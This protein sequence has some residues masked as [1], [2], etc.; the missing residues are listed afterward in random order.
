MKELVFI[1]SENLNCEP[2]TTD[3]VVAEL[4]GIK[5]DSVKSLI[6]R[7]KERLELFGKVKYRMQRSSKS[8]N[9][10]GGQC[11]KTYLLNEQQALQVVDWTRNL[12]RNNQQAAKIKDELIRLFKTTLKMP[13]M[14]R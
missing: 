4:I 1:E 13:E 8:S 5:T 11:R 14:A 9:G 3:E 12:N 10:K 6:R 2:F 7:H